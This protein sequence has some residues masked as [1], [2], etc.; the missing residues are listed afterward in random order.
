MARRGHATTTRITPLQQMAASCSGAFLTSLF[1]TPL[2]VVKI[3][4]Q[5][6]Q[7]PFAK[8]NCFLYC[9]G[10]MDHLCVCLNGNNTS[11]IRP[12]YRMPGKFNGTLDAF[13]QI[14]RKEGLKSLWSGLPPTLIMAVPATVV[15]FTAYDNL[16]EAMGFVPGKKNYTVP[17]VA[18]SIARIIAVTAISPLELIRTKMQSKKLTYQELKSCIRSS[19]QSG[20]VL[21]LYRGWGPTVLRDVPFSALYWLN[22]EYLKSELCEIYHTEEPTL[23]MSFFA[24]ATSGTIA[25]VLTLPFDV[26]KTHRQIEMGEMETRQRA[27]QSSSTFI[28]MR[29]LWMQNGPKALFAGLTPRVVKVAPACAIMISCYE[30]FKSFFRRR[31]EQQKAALT[32]WE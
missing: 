5:A 18:G 30:G 28:L 9:N 15:Y 22:Y 14:S 26:I 7:K 11:S 10:L 23:V 20:G 2:D 1:V 17:I 32:A 27:P 16:K 4:L 13:V 8:G 21:S 3:R 25:A 12:W 24:G 6:Q 19:V 31:N 29:R